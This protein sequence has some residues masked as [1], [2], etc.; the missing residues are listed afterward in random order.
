MSDIVDVRLSSG[1][2]AGLRKLKARQQMNADTIS[3]GD[4][5]KIGYY[6]IAMSLAKL[7]D[8]EFTIPGSDL[9]LEAR[10]DELD[11]QEIDELAF[12][13]QAHF[14]PSIDVLKNESSAPS[15]ELS[16]EP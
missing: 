14:S 3:K 9:E 8:K 5:V 11:G 1:R 12:A 10:I 6:R 2:V 13:Y 4:P 7:D 15:Q 16:Q